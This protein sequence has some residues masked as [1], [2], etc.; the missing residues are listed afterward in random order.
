ML[1]A[2]HISSLSSVYLNSTEKSKQTSQLLFGEVCAVKSERDNFY[3]IENYNDK[4]CGWVIKT[5]FALIERSEYNILKEQQAQRVCLPLVETINLEDNT[6]VYLPAGSLIRAFNP[7]SKVFYVQGVKYCVRYD[8]I[9]AMPYG[10]ID[11][12]EKTAL[13][14]LNAP[15]M[16]GGK[17]ILGLDA[18]GYIQLIFSLC[19]YALPRSSQ[20][21]MNVGV[22][23]Y[24]LE[25]LRLGDVVFVSKDEVVI[26]SYIYLGEERFIGV[27]EKVK[28]CNLSEIDI[29]TYTITIRRLI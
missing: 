15:L 29:D 5:S 23:V 12:I 8:S 18:S 22:S 10:L 17:S 20:E 7:V 27:E 28:I 21:Q 3:Y 25:Q 4:H 9:I 11:S 1:Y 6:I 13:A 19:G 26:Y 24:S 2:I 14:F 16:Y